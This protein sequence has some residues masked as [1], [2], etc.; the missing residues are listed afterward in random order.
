MRKIK[1]IVCSNSAI[2][3]VDYPKDIEIFRSK[4]HFGSE[5][6]EDF[7]E[8]P[9]ADFYNR[10]AANP[11]DI[12]KT[13]YTSLG[14]MLEYFNKLE[15]E[16]YTDAIVITI[17][18]PL[19]G[20]CAAVQ[21]LSTETKLNVIAYDSRILA[22]PEAYMALTAQS[23]VENGANVEE[24]LQVLDFIRDN[25]HMYFTVDTLLYLVKNGRLS[26]LQGTLGTML[27]LKPVL[28]FSKEGKVETLEKIRTTNKALKRVVELYL[29][30]TKDQDVITFISHAHADEN[31]ALVK[32]LIKEV[33][34]ERE[35][36]VTYLT[37]VVG[38]HTGPKALGLGYI[39]KQ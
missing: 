14:H 29:E 10:I 33:Y 34:P 16:G 39:K 25:N 27:A 35:I 5:S 12:P 7:V 13:S 37:P 2:D 36:V 18:R 32:E 23:M 20:M 15:S 9:A 22:Y 1:I 3:Y 19:S 30:E 4:L 11:N 28:T 26:K 38:A 21:Q 6:Y 24:I 17:A 8:M 31:V